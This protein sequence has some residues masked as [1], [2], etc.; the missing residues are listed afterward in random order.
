MTAI[1]Q[2]SLAGGELSSKLYARTDTVK[3][4]TGARTVRN[5]IVLKEGGIS[6]RAGLEFITPAKD[7]D[8]ESVLIPFIFNDEQAYVLEFGDFYMR[9]VRNG[10]QLTVTGAAWSNVTAYVIGDVVSRL[11]VN[12][13]CILAHTN[14]QPPNATYWYAMPANNIYEI[15]TPYAVAYLELLKYNQSLDVVT[16]TEQTYPIAEL[17][18]TGH[19]SW[20]IT[21][22]VFTP[23]QVAPTSPSNTGGGAG[24]AAD[25]VITAVNS[26]SFEE[27]LQST[28][29]TSAAAPT[30]GSPIT[31]S[32][33]AA[34]GAGEYNVYKK[35]N[36]VYGFI[37]VAVG[38]S[39][40]D[41][42][43][44]AD[45]TDTPPTERNPFGS[46]GNYPAT[47][48]YVQQRRTF[49]NTLNNQE[50]IWMSRSG[51]FNNFT[52]SSPQQDDDAITFSVPGRQYNEVR[53]I[54]DLEEMLIFTRGSIQVA[55]GD[56][57]GTITP[58]EVNPRGKAY[59]GAS[60][61]TPVI[62]GTS[63][64][65]V[66][67]R[68]N[69]VRDLF[70]DLTVGYKETD[71]TIF[72]SHLFKGYTIVDMAYQENPNSIIWVIRQRNSTGERSLIGLTYV[73][74]HEVWAWHRHDT[75]GEPRRL[76]V[77]PEGA[78]DKLYLIIK[79][80]I[81]G[82]TK[83]YIER[84]YSREIEDGEVIDSV[85][86]DSALTYD[87]RN[88]NPAL[89]MTLSGG[90]TW[91]SD[92]E[93]TLTASSS[94]F[95]IGDVGN[96]IHLTGP[97]GTLIRCVILDY[98][99]VDTVI[100]KPQKNVPVSMRNVAMATWGK[101]VDQVSGLSHLEAKDVGI[102]ADRFVVASPNNASHTIRT[103]SS[104][105]VTLDRCY[106][107]IHVGLPYISDLETLDIDTVNGETMIDKKK[108]IGKVVTYL[109]ESRGLWYGSAPPTDDEDDPLENLL[110][111]KLRDMEG[112]DDAVDLL[113]G[114]ADIN[115]M[116]DWNSNGRV[117]I[118]Q[119]DPLPATILSVTPVGMLPIR[120]G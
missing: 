62:V 87:G 74:E 37:G 39:F 119:V 103:V 15:P 49:A 56:T 29:T 82:A 36:G 26:E 32:W 38:T 116:S 65:Y 27:S 105:A 76:C 13:Y 53:H 21:S 43:I 25:W 33:T 55:K 79:R 23:G 106:V 68:G 101:A 75:D 61:V 70:G 48:T 7:P 57:S 67:A 104:A 72:S 6:N 47:S 120:T 84:M 45:A 93:L 107:V 81:N 59:R 88:T 95:V 46:S 44:I 14:Q 89:T 91:S 54:I 64:V 58:T 83:R 17:R 114:P 100:V 1:Q 40:I 28:A 102:F 35:I 4:Q 60:I 98:T 66:Q 99:D 30:S 3:Y 110:E 10:V 117:F 31:V 2:R 42:G 41:N 50:K 115:I 63:I 12:Y 19:T 97:D 9:V 52:Y 94:F 92:E 77:V 71:L 20:T 18:R 5:N 90:V 16:L 24:T 85:F 109:E 80:T 112:Y 22:V 8:D 108:I 73:K 86:L 111:L 69:V 118:R 96:E 78:E 11:G 113:T 34:A 51:K